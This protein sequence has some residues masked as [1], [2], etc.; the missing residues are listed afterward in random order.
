MWKPDTDNQ[1]LP[2]LVPLMEV[3]KYNIQCNM[4]TLMG[5]Y[6]EV[7]IIINKYKIF[8]KLLIKSK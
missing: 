8:G 6:C 5:N 4:K 2:R 7:E 3:H 1:V